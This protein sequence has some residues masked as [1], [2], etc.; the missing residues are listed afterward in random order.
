[1]ADYDL[2]ELAP[3]AEA[4]KWLPTPKGGQQTPCIMRRAIRR[5]LR[6]VKFSVH[7]A[8]ARAGIE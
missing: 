2:S 6:H 3:L 4:C 5:G 7:P 8:E 1:M